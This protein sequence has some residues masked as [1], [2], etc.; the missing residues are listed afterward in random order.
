M[1]R[2]L[3]EVSRGI[4]GKAQLLIAAFGRALEVI[5]RQ[6]ADNAGF[7]STDIMNRLRQKHA[8]WGASGQAGSGPDPAVCWW[9]V[10]IDREGICDTYERGVWEPVASKIN[11]LGSATE[12]ATLI[13]S[14]DE[15]VRNPK[16]QQPD[17]GPGGPGG[18]M[19]GRG[20]GRGAPMSAA[21]GGGGM[22]G[23]V[24]GGRGRGVRMMQGKGGK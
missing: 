21:L 7:D 13:L 6:L 15:T 11:S 16:S 20:M 14:V 24:G 10:D 2:H 8:T 5:P 12:A 18:S 22:R 9:G 4:E 17:G 1:S 19:G 23:M 3:K